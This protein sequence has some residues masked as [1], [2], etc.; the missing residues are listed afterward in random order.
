MLLLALLLA[1]APVKDRVA[2]LAR[3][4][5]AKELKVAPQKIQ[6][7]SVQPK[8]WPDAGLGCPEPGRM[9]AQMITPGFE[10]VLE[11]KGRKYTYHSDQK[12]VV[13]CDR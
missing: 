9:Y 13:R 3:E 7:K 6:T 4:D 5:L 11:A 8:E 12:R 10:I 1:T 2:Q